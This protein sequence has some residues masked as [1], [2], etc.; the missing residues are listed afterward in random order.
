MIPIPPTSRLIAATAAEQDGER[1][2][3]GADGLLEGGLVEDLVV[4]RDGAADAVPLVEH[5]GD[6][7]LGGVHRVGRRGLHE[8]LAERPEPGEALL[9]RGQRRDGEVVGVL[10]P[11]RRPGL[12]EHPDDRE[13]HPGDGDLL[14]DRV[15]RAEQVLGHGLPDDDDLAGGQDVVVEEVGALGDGLVGGLEVARVGAHD[16]LD[17]VGGPFVRRR[18]RVRRDDR[19]HRGHRGRGGLVG[20]RPGVVHGQRPGLGARPGGLP[21]G[22]EKPPEVDELTVSVLAPS[23]AMFFWIDCEEPS[24][25][26]TSR[27]TAATPIRMPSVVSA[28]RILLAASPRTANRTISTALTRSPPGDRGEPR[29]QAVDGGEPGVLDDPG[30]PAAGSPAWRVRRRRAR[31]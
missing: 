19:R 26:A 8:D 11:A 14:A 7:G 1:R 10:E 24:P 9:H 6:L 21:G 20:E 17:R 15:D 31:G 22:E 28:E 30:R 2:G 3:R 5:R 18:L 13:R 12:L 25:T 4:G 23:W 27:I 16:L 29:R